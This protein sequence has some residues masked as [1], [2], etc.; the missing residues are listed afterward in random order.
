MGL[1]VSGF[2]EV[3]G[4]FGGRILGEDFAAGLADGFVTSRPDLSEQGLELCEDLLDGVE[5]GGVFRQEHQAGSDI[6]DRLAHRLSFVGSEIVEDDDV[7]R[8]Q[9]RHE[10]LIDI[11]AETLA[12][13]GSVKQAGRVDA[14]VAQGGEERR[15]LPLALRDLVDE[16]LS[17]RAQPR[18]LVMLVFVQ[19]S[20]MKTRR[21]GSMC[22][23]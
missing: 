3:C 13:D 6:P 18:S 20:S 8:F 10:E 12:V 2:F 21:R 14:V 5:V 17:L 1:R 22:P 16:A 7:A 9:R 15:G 23:W 11:G 4:A 19:V